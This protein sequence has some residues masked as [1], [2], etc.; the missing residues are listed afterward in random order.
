MSNYPRLDETGLTRL[1][2]KLAEKIKAK[3]DPDGDSQNNTAT[4]TSSDVADGSATSW[5]SVSKLNSGET[6]SSIFAKVS[7]MF[8]NI[9]YLY[10]ILGNT[11]ISSLG[12]GTVTSALTTLN[13]SLGNKANTSDLA[14]VA[15]SG[16][17]SDLSDKP[18]I[19][20][21][22]V[23]SSSSNGLAPKVT[24]TSGYLKGDG[25]WSVPTN[26][27]YTGLPDV[28]VSTA[29]ATQA[30]VG[31]SPNYKL[32]SGARFTVRIANANT[33]SGVITLNINSTGAKNIYIDGSVSSSSNNTLPAGDYSV[34]YDGSYY[35]FNTADEITTLNNDLTAMGFT[36]I[37]DSSTFHL[38]QNDR[39]VHIFFDQYPVTE[40]IL[41]NIASLGEDPRIKL[42]LYP[43]LN[44]VCR[45]GSTLAIADVETNGKL[46]LYT[47]GLTTYTTGSIRGEL[48][49]IHS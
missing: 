31:T 2:N 29:A 36:K 41:G 43:S 24:N 7:Q 49:Y 10:K 35:Y 40:A 25:T 1:V 46:S 48:I 42:P 4:F 21:Y 11:D 15:T 17:Y 23:V 33:Y 19:P 26:T 32:R 13:T 30:K 16:S 38:W 37:I 27:T 20:S 39:E 14:T 6:H 5:T 45:I 22:G 8:K 18:T 12:S 47:D 3:Q 28:Y 34:Y 44:Y 9:R